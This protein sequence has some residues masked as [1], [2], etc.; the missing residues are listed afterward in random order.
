M[1]AKA[2]PIPT[3]EADPLMMNYFPLKF[4]QA[5]SDKAKYLPQQG[6][7]QRQQQQFARS[8]AAPAKTGKRTRR[9]NAAQRL[10]SAIA[11][12][13]TNKSTNERTNEQNWLKMRMK[14]EHMRMKKCAQGKERKE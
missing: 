2:T 9:S 6:R 7:C 10:R 13:T 3:S 14:M 5:E 8:R 11:A 12:T 1:D 4:Q